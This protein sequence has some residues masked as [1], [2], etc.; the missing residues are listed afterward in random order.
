M[1]IKPLPKQYFQVKL[2]PDMINH[3]GVC[4]SI[5][6]SQVYSRLRFGIIVLLETND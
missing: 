3:G 4:I 2:I 1:H 6:I 5:N